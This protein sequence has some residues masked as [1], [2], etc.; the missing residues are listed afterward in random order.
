MNNTSNWWE[1]NNNNM[2][3]QGS[4]SQQKKRPSK[5][6]D[7]DELGSL[8]KNKQSPQGGYNSNK[9]K[10]LDANVRVSPKYDNFDTSHSGKEK[11]DDSHKVISNF[12]T[13]N[14]QDVRVRKGSILSPKDSNNTGKIYSPQT[15]SNFENAYTNKNQGKN[16][17]S[18]YNSP[19]PI[20]HKKPDRKES[21]EQKSKKKNNY[22][23]KES[24]NDISESYNDDFDDDFEDADGGFESIGSEIEDEEIKDDFGKSSGGFDMADSNGTNAFM[25][26][27]GPIEPVKE[28]KID[29]YNT[30]DMNKLTKD[31]ADLEKAKM[32]ETMKTN[33]I[34][35]GDER[36]EYD[37]EVDFGA[38]DDEGDDC[39]W[40]EEEDD[41][42]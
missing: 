37:K 35:K 13:V 3:R 1:N 23:K 20:S 25:K 17:K 30:F 8:T 22:S 10:P 40:D 28:V 24:R 11:L 4:T 5:L 36:F 39:S 33:F 6:N 7:A 19:E 14:N 29:D 31:Q 9:I 34:G 18:E 12:K 16:H 41:D 2:S 42:W 32:N 38:N 27:S 21:S 15:N 26:K